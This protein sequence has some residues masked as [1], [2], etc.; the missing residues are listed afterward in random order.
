M[1]ADQH[2]GCST[3][4]TQSYKAGEFAENHTGASSFSLKEDDEF[5]DLEQGYGAQ[6][7]T[8]LKL[9]ESV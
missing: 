4:F 8:Q 6:H 2:G 7:Q 5:V 3:N 1:R 9:K